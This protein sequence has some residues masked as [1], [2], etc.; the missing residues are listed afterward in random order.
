M[1]DNVFTI[2]LGTSKR[3]IPF[4]QGWNVNASNPINNLEMIKDIEEAINWMG[5]I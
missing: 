4:F 2:V 3:S 5:L 1:G